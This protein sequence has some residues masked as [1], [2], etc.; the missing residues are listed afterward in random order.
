MTRICCLAFLALAASVSAQQPVPAAVRWDALLAQPAAW[1]GTSEAVRIADNL[2]LYQR[3]TGG[4]P[5]NADMT[6]VLAQADRER[7]AAEKPQTDSTIDNGATT[8][9]VQTLARVFTAT[10]LARFRDGAIAGLDYVLRAQYPNGGW[11]Q[12]FPLRNDYSR[13]ITFNDDAIVRVLTM[14]R[15]IADGEAPYGFVDAD[16][17]A[18]AETAA[19][20]GLEIILATQIRV[21]GE[22]TVWCAQHDAATLAP[23]LARTYELPSFSGSESVKIVR[24]L[25]SLPDPSP[26]VVA[27]VDAAVSWLRT[28]AL[29]GIRVERRS[30][31]STPRG[32]D[33]FVVDDP[34]APLLWARFY[35]LETAKPIFVGRDGVKREKLS[36]IEYERRTGYSY[37]GAYAT[38]LLDEEYPA[39]T[40]ARG[41][42]GR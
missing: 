35:D 3:S 22:L 11:P 39:W 13:H 17:R 27:A 20:R 4:W 28:H 19:T 12:Y 21:D 7:L 2:L 10:S 6:A 16:R 15:E 36:D 33:L 38:S 9:E 31:P 1:Y 23:A 25:M 32:Y 8:T 42:L 30:D 14:L 29:R 5:K 40:R 41:R 26:R 34:G 18:R 24:Y 37:L